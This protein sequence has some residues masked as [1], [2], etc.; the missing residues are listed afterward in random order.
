MNSLASE[1]RGKIIKPSEKDGISAKKNEKNIFLGSKWADGG[2]KKPSI[3]YLR[4]KN[5]DMDF[6]SLGFLIQL[7]FFAGAVYLYLFSSGLYKPKSMTEKDAETW[8][9]ENAKWI[10]PLSLM[11]AAVMLM[12]LLLYFIGK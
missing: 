12:N 3:A 8:R 9:R 11:L 10:K 4:G 5:N 2:F 7:T 6:F 1:I